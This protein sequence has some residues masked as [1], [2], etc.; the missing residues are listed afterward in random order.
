MDK[1]T[2]I[3]PYKGKTFSNKKKWA[4]KPQKNPS[5]KLKCILSSE[6]NQCERAICCI[7]PTI[8]HSEK[9]KTADTAKGSVVARD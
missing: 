1:Q 8:W 2:A 4:T 3:H 5:R 7:N 9:W 6:R